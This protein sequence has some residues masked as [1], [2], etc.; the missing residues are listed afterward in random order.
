MR[1]PHRIPTI[2]L[3]LSSFFYTNPLIGQNTKTWVVPFDLVQQKYVLLDVTINSS[4]TLSFILDTGAATSLL[5]KDRAEEL[6]I[7][8]NYQQ[9]VDGA[10]G[11]KT[12]DVALGQTVRLSDLTLKGVN[13]V[14]EDLDKLGKKLA[15]PFDGI[16]GFELFKR[17]VTKLSFEEN[18]LT[19]YP[20]GVMP[21]LEEFTKHEF[22]F[23]RGIPI[24]QLKAG[25]SLSSGDT[26]S[27]EVFFDSGAGLTLL[28]NTPF[29]KQHNL[30]RFAEDVSGEQAEGLGGSST[31]K[32]I[33]IDQFRLEP[34][35]FKNMRI[36]LSG[37][38]S[39]VSSYEGYMGIMGADII[40]KFTVILDYSSKQLYLKPNKSYT[41]EKN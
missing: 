33:Q 10:S 28:I 36:K 2:L 19:F 27:G 41:G 26:L 7:E 3:F 15:T 17:Y 32:S 9:K 21:D 16:I 24:P 37:N 23:G 12:Y 5:D 40:S 18:R 34:Y 30:S 13:F 35:S 8:A 1:H 29:G 31:F 25:I 4:D 39:G 22:R 6:G 38:S 14:L 20:L 11:T